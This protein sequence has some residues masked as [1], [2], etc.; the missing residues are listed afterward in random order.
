VLLSDLAERGILRNT[1]IGEHNIEPSLL[2]LNVREE[3]IQIA[4]VRDVSL[5]AGDISSD[6]FYRRR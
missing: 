5:D 2:P 4:K 6:L 3:V 1:G